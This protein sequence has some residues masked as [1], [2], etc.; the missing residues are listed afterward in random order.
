[1]DSR[2]WFSLFQ[3]P[4]G[5]PDYVFLFLCPW[6]TFP[7]ST[8]YATAYSWHRFN[9]MLASSFSLHLLTQ[10]FPYVSADSTANCRSPPGKPPTPKISQQ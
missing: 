3:A 7:S 1:M 2:C 10:V 6:F 9:N 8:P 4:Q 5:T